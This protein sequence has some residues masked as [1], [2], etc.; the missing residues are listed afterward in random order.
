MDEL[1][2]Q[3]LEE[4][5]SQIKCP[6]HFKCL[7]LHDRLYGTS[8]RVGYTDLFECEQLHSIGC[9]FIIHYG[10]RNYCNCPMCL[11]LNQRSNESTPSQT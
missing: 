10:N 1:Y 4:L 3:K 5:K 2:Q 8:K 11:F 7:A 9:D 6:H